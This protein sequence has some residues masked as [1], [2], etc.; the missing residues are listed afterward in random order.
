MEASRTY[1]FPIV[2]QKPTE[3]SI[4]LW[5]RRFG[6]L[7]LDNVQKTSKIVKEIKLKKDEFVSQKDE[8]LRLC[9]PCEKEKATRHIR[10]HAKPR[11]LK[12]FDEVHIN[13]VMITPQGIGKKKY[14]IV[15][16][17]KATSTR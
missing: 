3:T 8:D 9:N 15:F 14:T 1:A 11:N 13:V 10:K 6:H 4:R 12:M 5:H 16:T 2:T 17:E 7:S